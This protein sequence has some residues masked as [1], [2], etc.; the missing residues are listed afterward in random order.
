MVWSHM[1]DSLTALGRVLQT[2]DFSGFGS[3]YQH[4]IQESPRMQWSLFCCKTFSMISLRLRR[5]QPDI[6]D[7]D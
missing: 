1:Q 5:M 2:K 7:H 3:D 6:M 4:I